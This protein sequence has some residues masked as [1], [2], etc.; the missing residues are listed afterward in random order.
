MAGATRAE[1]YAALGVA[2]MEQHG[3]PR[4]EVK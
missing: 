2:G 1:V 4:R 3:A